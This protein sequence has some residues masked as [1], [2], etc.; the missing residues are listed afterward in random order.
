MLTR[1]MLS[2][3]AAGLCSAALSLPALAD[4]KKGTAV[5]KGKVVL[6]AAA[7]APK[8]KPLDM[9]ADAVCAKAHDKAQPDEGLIVYA[10]E[11]NAVPFVFVYVKKGID[12]KY[13]VPEEPVVLD[14]KGCMYVPHV[15]G[16]IAGQGLDIL[17]SDPVNHNVHSLAARNPK[18]N[19]AQ[20]NQ[21]MKKEL[22][23]K[24][25]F[26]RPE[27]MI[28]VK[29]D[30]HGW[31]ASYI[32]VVS[33]PFFSVT[34]S[35]Q[36]DGG[37]KAARGTFEIKELPAGKFEL[38]FWHE[39]LGVVTQEVEVADGET[40]EI[41]VKIGGK[42]ALAPT[43]REIELSAADDSNKSLKDSCCTKQKPADAKC[44]DEAPKAE[45]TK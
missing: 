45:V 31:M 34:K 30:V 28:K 15:M 17:N 36:N 18:F 43:V 24:D 39:N 11:G 13:D 8:I 44:H 9:K 21:G 38:E 23:G 16:M 2:I 19:F 1:R 29:C 25:T 6:D 40:K 41:E 35:H 14:Q 3:V 26:T 42:K 5:I 20:P 27:V 37:D 7:T 33:H 32:G 12:D 4:G 22:R 10:S